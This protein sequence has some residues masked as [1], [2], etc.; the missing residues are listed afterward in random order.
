MKKYFKEI[1]ILI[2]QLLMFYVFPLTAEPTDAMGMVFINYSC[3]LHTCD[4][5]GQCIKEKSQVCVSAFGF[6]SFYSFRFHLL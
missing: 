3:N 1:A 4:N 5:Y 6:C 2:A